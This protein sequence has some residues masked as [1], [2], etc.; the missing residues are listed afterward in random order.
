MMVLLTC[1]PLTSFAI[2]TSNPNFRINGFSTLGLTYADNPTFGVRDDVGQEGIFNEWSLKPNSRIGLQLNYQYSPRIKAGLQ[3]IAKDHYEGGPL[4]DALHWAY[5]DFKL[6]SMFELRVGRMGQDLF[7]LSDY[8]NV[9]FAQLWA[10]APIE[11]YGQLTTEYKDGLQLRLVKDAFGGQFFGQLS[12]T[13]ANASSLRSG[14]LQSFGFDFG[15]NVDLSLAWENDTWLFRFSHSA[16][17]A[18][19]DQDLLEPIQAILSEAV[20][21]G[22]SDI[23][24]W[25]DEFQI[26]G[27]QI[28]YTSFGIKFTQ[29]DWLIQSEF[30]HIDTGSDIA[31]NSNSAYV[32]IGK[33]INQ[34]TPFIVGSKAWNSQAVLPDAPAYLSAY[35]TGTQAIVDTFHIAQKT[36]GL[37]LR[38]DV[39]H[40][41]AVK[42]QFDRTWV[43]AN[44]AYLLDSYQIPSQADA[45]DRYTLTV[46]WVF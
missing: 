27:N 13:K 6:N 14:N 38:W 29:S 35:Q 5:V 43:K 2:D 23:A 24:P 31:T 41:V 15:E 45:I 25:I 12:L 37:G 32:L 17:K 3:L 18:S 46:D 21:Y 11:F 4:H 20:A 7:M 10:H 36:L 42:A 9:G 34:F 26:D 30:N 39:A 22:W 33:H 44:G 40:N 8:R 16:G 28:T 19:A 1:L